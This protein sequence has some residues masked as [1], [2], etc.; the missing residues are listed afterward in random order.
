[1][2]FICLI[3]LCGAVLTGCSAAP[4]S[5]FESVRQIT[6]ERTGGARTTW[7][8]SA[9]ADALVAREVDDMLAQPLMPDQAVQIALLSHPKLQAEYEHLGVAQADLVEAGLLRN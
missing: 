4:P 1:M 2:R 5:G 6:E 7:R 8:S 3:M 9:M